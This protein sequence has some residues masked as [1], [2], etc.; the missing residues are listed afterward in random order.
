MDLEKTKNVSKLDQTKHESRIK[1]QS[2]QNLDPN[3]IGDYK[4][5]ELPSP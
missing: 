3:L 4:R 2:K 5:F 1:I